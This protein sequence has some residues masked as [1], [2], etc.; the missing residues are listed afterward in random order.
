MSSRDRIGNHEEGSVMK[1]FENGVCASNDRHQFLGGRNCQ[2]AKGHYIAEV[3]IDVGCKI[4]P[5][6]RLDKV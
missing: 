2:E 4:I 6:N 5:V 3:R 1:P